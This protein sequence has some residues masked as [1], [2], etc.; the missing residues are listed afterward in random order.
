MVEQKRRQIMFNRS[1]RTFKMIQEQNR[2]EEIIMARDKRAMEYN[3]KFGFG[4]SYKKRVLNKST[5]VVI[6]CNDK[7]C[8][9]APK[10]QKEAR[11]ISADERVRQPDKISEKSEHSKTH[12]SIEG[13]S[14]P[15]LD[16]NSTIEF[17]TPNKK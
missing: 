10:P 12:S 13:S 2:L 15:V 3:I 9:I 16:K 7:R 8:L 11:T 1:Y 6:Q 5:S 14:F 4:S 17:P